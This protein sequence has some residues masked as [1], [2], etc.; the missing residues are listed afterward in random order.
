[1]GQVLN[2]NSTPCSHFWWWWLGQTVW[3]GDT[4]RSCVAKLFFSCPL[5]GH[6]CLYS[7]SSFTLVSHQPPLWIHIMFLFQQSLFAEPLSIQSNSVQVLKALWEKT[8]LKGMHSFE[9]AMIQ[10]TFPH[11]KDLDHVQM[12]L[13]E[14][15]FFDLFGYSEEAGAWQCFM[16]NN[17]EKATAVGITQGPREP[18][19]DTHLEITES[20]I[21][22]RVLSSKTQYV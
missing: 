13:E 20:G 10:S 22:C 8:Q 2:Q 15:R 19:C 1:M 7:K 4:V 9:T 5:K 14:V 12:H 21:W 11:Q 17:P 16:C 6:Y 18:S 3:E